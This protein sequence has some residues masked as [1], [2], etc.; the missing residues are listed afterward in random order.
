MYYRLKTSTPLI[1]GIIILAGFSFVQVQ[2]V[3]VDSL[4]FYV[5]TADVK[6]GGT[7]DKIYVKLNDRNKS[8]IDSPTKYNDLIRELLRLILSQK[9]Q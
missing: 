2:A 3:D 7:D 4:E 5:K 9:E 6:Y 8:F 1:A